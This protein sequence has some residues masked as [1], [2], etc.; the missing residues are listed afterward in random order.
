LHYLH[1][2]LVVGQP[3]DGLAWARSGEAI[4]TG[5]GR[6]FAF[7]AQLALFIEGIA[8]QR[9]AVPFAH[10][11]HLLHLFTQEGNAAVPG[12]TA[13]RTAFNELKA[14]LRNAGGLAGVLCADL[15]GVADAPDGQETAR[16]LATSTARECLAIYAPVLP[17]ELPALDPLEFR[18]LILHRLQRYSADDLRHWLRH[19]S[20]PPLR[21]VPARLAEVVQRRPP[22]VAERLAGAVR[23]RAR[24]A[25]ALG[26]V[27]TLLAALTLPPRRPAD[28]ALPLGGYADV[29]TTGHPERL[30]PSQF[31]LEG[32][33][34]V[35]R[36]AERELLYFRREEPQHRLTEELVVVLDQGV[37]TW[38]AV[39]LGLAATVLALSKSAGPQRPFRLIVTSVSE[40]VF[41]PLTDRS[42]ELGIALEASDLTAHP[43][44]ALTTALGPSHSVLRDVVLLTHPRTLTESAVQTVAAQVPAATRLFAVSLEATG[45]VELA[46]LRHGHPVRL[47]G[48]RVDLTPVPPR[49]PPRLA[50][51]D[52]LPPWR[53]AIEPVPFPFAFGLNGKLVAVAF[54]A[55]GEWLA[56]VTP[57]GIVQVWKLD[58]TRHELLP[59]GFQGGQVIVLIDALLGVADGFAV[60]GRLAGEFVV[61]HYALAARQVT[62]YTLEKV[63]TTPARWAYLAELHCVVQWAPT[64]THAAAVDL[65]TGGVQL[66]ASALQ[67]R[68][69]T[70]SGTSNIVSTLLN[71]SLTARARAAASQFP[72]LTYAPGSVGININDRL[73]HTPAPCVR[74]DAHHG[75]L[76]YDGP[77]P[78][79]PPLEPHRDGQAQLV[80]AYPRA[81]QARGETLVVQTQWNE[82]E[83]T[84][85][86]I[87]RGP[88]GQLVRRIEQARQR[89]LFTLSADG[90]RLAWQTGTCALAWIDLDTPTEE[91]ALPPGQYHTQ[92]RV[93]L[94]DGW[95]LVDVGKGAH[96]LNWRDGPL[97]L[98]YHKSTVN[99]LAQLA[100]EEGFELTGQ[101]ADHGLLECVRYDAR[102]FVAKAWGTLLVTVD[103]FGQVAVFAPQQNQRLVAMFH[104]F[105]KEVA[106]WMPDGTRFGPPALVGGP[107]TPACFERFGAALR[108]ATGVGE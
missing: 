37:R 64:N 9:P 90:M 81:A 70:D 97:R 58:G 38:G 94:G 17:I 39:R 27:P 14:P 3:L 65:E 16:W 34:F 78:P 44:A 83:P 86:W 7:A 68:S 69:P 79:W 6:T 92:L 4:E 36:F 61:V 74:F 18:R 1:I 101:V 48:C 21:T 15:P 28:W 42:D 24:L 63:V 50:P 46:Q 51:T 93:E 43:A 25:G 72:K 23:E 98:G 19:G 77:D 8:E 30:L 41:D 91:Q 11:L 5:T 104:F 100:V 52:A 108:A 75:R 99:T 103:V 84:S 67:L 12:N 106:G 29:T 89:G 87:W 60:C 76:H 2:P 49:T 59:R 45:T 40:R 47:G 85:L 71:P 26:M 95:L 80:R 32:D 10:V 73:P 33:E 107:T 35:R 57:Q 20:P 53:G 96:L 55:A 105:R 88:A 62:V 22:T 13:L 56:A 54:D 66:S 82:L 102:R 31:A